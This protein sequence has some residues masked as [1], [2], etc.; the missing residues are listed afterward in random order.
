VIYYI[1]IRELRNRLTLIKEVNN[2]TDLPTNGNGHGEYAPEKEYEVLDVD[3]W[4][5]II[6]RDSDDKGNV[7]VVETKEVLEELEIEDEESEN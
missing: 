2:I 5:N 4:G 6:W 1:N 7:K 3:Y